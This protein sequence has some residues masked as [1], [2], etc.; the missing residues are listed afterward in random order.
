MSKKFDNEYFRKKHAER[1][2]RKPLLQ[3]KRLYVVNINGKK[4]AILQ[5]S[6]LK[7]DTI[8]V[9]QFQKSADIIQCF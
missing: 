8:S 1:R 4:Y 5:K 2:K 9:E 3:K 6:Q 7:I